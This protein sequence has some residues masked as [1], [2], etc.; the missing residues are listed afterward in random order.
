MIRILYDSHPKYLCIDIYRGYQTFS[1]LMPDKYFP[2]MGSRSSDHPPWHQV[3]Q[4][5]PN[6]ATASKGCRFWLRTPSPW[7]P[8]SDPRVNASKGDGRIR[9]PWVPAHKP[10][11]RPQRRLL[12][13]RPPRRAHHRP[14]PYRAWPRPRAPPTPHHRMGKASTHT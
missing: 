7:K 12:L 2:T 6:R 5:S 9:G 4:H 13:R 10:A 8:W 14:T 11:H 1:I 3:V